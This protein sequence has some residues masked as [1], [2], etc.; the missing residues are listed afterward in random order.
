MPSDW[1]KTHV[2]SQC[3]TE[4]LLRSSVL[5]QDVVIRFEEIQC[6]AMP[7]QS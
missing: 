3:K 5:L 7:G 2:L 6:S 1:S 4:E